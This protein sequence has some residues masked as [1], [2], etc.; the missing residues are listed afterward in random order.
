MN[1]DLIAFRDPDG[2]EA[3]DVAR[4][5]MHAFGG[6][7]PTWLPGFDAEAVGM[8][9]RIRL[10]SLVRYH[11]DAAAMMGGGGEETTSPNQ[12]DHVVFAWVE[13]DGDIGLQITVTSFAVGL[14]LPIG[15][16]VDERAVSAVERV[17]RVLREDV[18]LTVFDPH[19]E[20]VI[21]DPGEPDTMH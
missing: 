6:G 5:V 21:D 2:L 7:D 4:L 11:S 19:S 20:Q 15:E 10:P 9:L 13:E 18:R 17:L 14:V 3:A 12:S 8:L 16:T 1:F